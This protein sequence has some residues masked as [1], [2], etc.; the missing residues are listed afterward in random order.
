MF[1]TV[2]AV[3]FLSAAA[4]ASFAPASAAVVT[5]F[6]STTLQTGDDFFAGPVNLG[7]SANYFGNAKT[8]AFISSNGY[9]TFNSGQSGYNPVGLGA[10][11]TGQPI[12]A[13]FYADADTGRGGTIGYGTGLFNGRSAFGVTWNNVGVFGGSTDDKRNSFQI[14]LVDRGET[15]AGNF[16]IVLNYDKI[17][18]ETGSASSSGG[19]NGLGG[20]SAAAGYNAGTGNQPGTF[21]EFAGSRVNGAFLDGGPNALAQNSNVGLAGRYVFNVRGGNVAPPPA[22]VPEPATWAM[23]IGGFALAGA[24]ARRRGGQKAVLA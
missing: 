20:N 18:W 15:G 24:T 22:G 3:A 7:F 21:F 13:A 6:S 4:T 12:I 9:L 17:Q 14:L 11:Y 19:R 1:K 5:G 8:S 10:G 23:M 16:D 2:L